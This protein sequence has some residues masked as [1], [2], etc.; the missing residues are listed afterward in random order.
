M[1]TSKQ[2][3]ATAEATEDNRTSGRKRV[4]TGRE[5]EGSDRVQMSVFASEISGKAIANSLPLSISPS[6]LA[7]TRTAHANERN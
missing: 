7:K 1:R 2:L 5:L 3:N 4:V 6:E